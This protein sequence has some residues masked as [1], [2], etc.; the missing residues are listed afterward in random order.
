M[1]EQFQLQ[2]SKVDYSAVAGPVPCCP[3]RHILPCVSV[4]A[5]SARD[6]GWCCRSP[7]RWVRLRKIVTTAAVGR[8]NA[9]AQAAMI[10]SRSRR[11]KRS[12]ALLVICSLMACSSREW[13]SR[14]RT[15][16]RCFSHLL[17]R[18]PGSAAED[19]TLHGNPGDESHEEAEQQHASRG[20]GDHSPSHK[21]PPSRDRIT[22]V[23]RVAGL[24]GWWE[25]GGG[26]GRGAVR[27]I[28]RRGP[29]MGRCRNYESSVLRSATWALSRH[30]RPVQRFLAPAPH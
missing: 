30:R 4:S 8:L 23:Y 6:R 16:V 1:V 19:V 26:R 27:P 25:A 3:P 10:I 22:M 15:S 7:L 17:Q 13:R 12:F 14:K 11:E 29:R 20:I 2:S 5:H 21:S 18:R 28:Q 24:T 9:A